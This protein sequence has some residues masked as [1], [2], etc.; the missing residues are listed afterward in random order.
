MEKKRITWIDTVRA[1]AMIVVILG[2]MHVKELEHVWAYSF[3]MP[4]FFLISGAAYSLSSKAKNMNTWDYIKYRAKGLVLPYFCLNFLMLPVWILNFKIL[5]NTKTSLKSELLGIVVSNEG[6]IKCP[7]NATWF[8][9]ALFLTTVCYYLLEKMC[10]YDFAKIFLW[11]ILIGTCGFIVSFTKLRKIYLPWHMNVI[12]I[13][14]LYFGIGVGFMKSYSTIMKPFER[15]RYL[16]GILFFIIG[17]TAGILNGKVSMHANSYK[18]GLLFL[19][20]S[21]LISFSL[22]LLLQKIPEKTGG[23]LRFIGRNTLVITAVHCPMLR[24]LERFSP[25]TKAFV[26]NYPNVT[27]VL[28]LTAAML[29]AWIIKHY[30]PFMIGEKRKNRVV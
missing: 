13:A 28:I 22:V 26:Y 20:S 12:P 5:G 25:Q 23:Y 6:I 11:C 4:I 10:K 30:F 15:Y 14:L 1:A 9:T 27:A 3:H 17:S 29:V 18:N 7:S 21:V 2:H 8:F 24:F 19:M 16:Y